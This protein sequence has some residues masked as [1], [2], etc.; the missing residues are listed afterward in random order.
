ME[1]LASIL[2]PGLAELVPAVPEAHKFTNGRCEMDSKAKAEIAKA[3]LA[4]NARL[5]KTYD[6]DKPRASVREAVLATCQ[7]KELARLLVLA[8]EWPADC[9][10]W[11]EGIH[12]VKQDASRNTAKTRR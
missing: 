11:A 3:I 10:T 9:Q 1:T 12:G 7:D 2:Q 8:M 4:A 5:D 6:P